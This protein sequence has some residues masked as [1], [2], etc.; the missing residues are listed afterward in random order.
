MRPRWVGYWVWLFLW[1]WDHLIL[2]WI[3]WKR[4]WGFWVKKSKK[5]PKNL[6]SRLFQERIQEMIP[7]ELFKFITFHKISLCWC[8]KKKVFFIW[9]FFSEIFLRFFFRTQKRKKRSRLFFI[10]PIH[11][12]KENP[13]NPGNSGN[14]YKNHFTKSKRQKSLLKNEKN[15]LIKISF[16]FYFSI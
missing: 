2:E 11:S 13:G 1:I 8:G 4:T 3:F 6:S 10:F 15:Y 5:A 16:S 9:E 14:F 12:N 7:R